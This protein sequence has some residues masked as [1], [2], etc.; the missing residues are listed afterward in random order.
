MLVIAN[1]L[2]SGL[3]FGVRAWTEIWYVGDMYMLKVI[4]NEKKL[5]F[6]ELRYLVWKPSYN[7]AIVEYGIKSS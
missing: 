4:S 3:S 6:K 1:W 2:M 7:R 5:V